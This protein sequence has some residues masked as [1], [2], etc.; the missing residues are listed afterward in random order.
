MR[1]STHRASTRNLE[2]A[3]CAC[4]LHL[5]FVKRRDSCIR[6]GEQLCPGRARGGILIDSANRDEMVN[7]G[8]KVIELRDSVAEFRLINFEAGF[9]EFRE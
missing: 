7:A 9:V 2:H 5:K 4:A 1:A 3:G 6:V 8:F